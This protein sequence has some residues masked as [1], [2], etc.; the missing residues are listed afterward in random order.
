MWV[1]TA[2]HIQLG[3]AA[4]GTSGSPIPPWWPSWLQQL[5]P[6]IL[7]TPSCFQGGGTSALGRGASG[8]VALR[9]GWEQRVW[10]R[11]GVW[12]GL[13]APSTMCQGG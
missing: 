4:R 6:Q 3:I 10:G 9:G 7:G 8:S 11:H 12:T 13:G 5:S 1:F 2:L